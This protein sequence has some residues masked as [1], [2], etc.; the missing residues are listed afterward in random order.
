MGS[1]ADLVSWFKVFE[2]YTTYKMKLVGVV[3]AMKYGT[4]A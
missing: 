1:S 4:K 2:E 3:L